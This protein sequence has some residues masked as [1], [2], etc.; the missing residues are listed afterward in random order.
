MSSMIK[1]SMCAC[2]GQQ[3]KQRRIPLH[4]HPQWGTQ[5]MH[6][7]VCDKCFYS[8]HYLSNNEMHDELHR[9]E[10]QFK[11]DYVCLGFTPILE[12]KPEAMSYAI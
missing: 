4:A 8:L 3:A 9:R 6:W 1:W 11:K 2:C 12:A 10:E 5:V 7:D